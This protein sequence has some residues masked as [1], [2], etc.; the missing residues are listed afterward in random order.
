MPENRQDLA[1]LI[2]SMNL[3]DPRIAEAFLAVDRAGFVPPSLLEDDYL[4]RPVPIPESQTTSQPSLIALMIDAAA[5]GP[6]DRVLEVGTGYGF[7]TALL[8]RLA[9]EVVSVERHASLAQTARANLE[10]NGVTNASV[11]V[12][13]GWK[14]YEDKAP[15]D[16]IVVSAAASEV[17]EA[18][19]RQ[20]AEGGRLV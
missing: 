13:D 20:L 18:L 12:G 10:R 8:A 11:Y 1:R 7:Q 3:S 6:E 16:A 5:P 4:D 17:P 14:G 9:A 15:Y 19:T 2:A